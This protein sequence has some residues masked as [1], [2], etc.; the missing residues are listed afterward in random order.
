MADESSD[1]EIWI[2]IFIIVVII[3]IIVVVIFVVRPNG[4]EGA[5][6]SADRECKSGLFCS[7]DRVCTK[8]PGGG[9]GTVCTTNSNCDIGLFCFDGTCA[10]TPPLV[11]LR[12]PGTPCVT[13]AN[14]EANL[15]CINSV[16][17]P[18][19]VTGSTGTAVATTPTTTTSNALMNILA[20]NGTTLPTPIS[21]TPHP[22]F[23]QLFISYRAT[24][25]FFFDLEVNQLPN[26][27][28][29]IWVSQ[30]NQ[31]F[32]YNANTN[33][34]ILSSSHYGHSKVHQVAIK[35]DGSLTLL[36]PG[37]LTGTFPSGISSTKFFFRLE[38]NTVIL[39][40]QFN[41][42]FGVGTGAFAGVATFF[43]NDPTSYPAAPTGLVKQP[44]IIEL[45]SGEPSTNAD[46]V[47][48]EPMPLW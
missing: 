35:T 29:S 43:S 7:A 12:G 9:P 30:G 11:P 20:G 18:V 13:N 23:S 36:N 28:S 33:E 47:D 37:L 10:A 14:C 2:V 39:R 45:S 25:G 34:L 27:F 32:S 38:N 21:G 5:S 48:P 6:C 16:C 15:A 8:G 4:G 40:D 26:I 24:G 41:N 19:I 22:S 17:S 3:I 42:Q 1:S 31:L 44:V 46:L